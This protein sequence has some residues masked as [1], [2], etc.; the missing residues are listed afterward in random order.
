MR[1][2]QAPLPNDDIVWSKDKKESI[3]GVCVCLYVKTIIHF[4]LLL[5]A[6]V[7]QVGKRGEKQ[8]FLFETL[9]CVLPSS[10]PFAI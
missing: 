5:L 2:F 8:F 4:H 6:A 3:N 9:G 10:P 7:T 1:S